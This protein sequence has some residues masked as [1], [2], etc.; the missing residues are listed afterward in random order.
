MKFVIVT[1]GTEGDV[2]PLA[3]LAHALV[4]AGH[5][6]R[7][8][9]PAAAL[10]MAHALGVE[11]V[12]LA[13]NVDGGPAEAGGISGAVEQG[14]DFGGAAAAMARIANAHAEVWTRQTLAAAEGCD[15]IILS[16]LAAFVG[17]SVAERLGAKAI[18]AGFIPI[19]PTLAFPS[20][21]LPRFVPRP[22]NRFSHRLVNGLLWR[23]FSNAMNAARGT[24]L[25][26]PPRRAVW[27]DH[28]MLY[29]VS[30]SIL[31]QPADWPDNA[32]VCGQW[33]APAGDWAPP[34]DLSAFLSAG[35]PP[36]YVGFGSMTGFD[37]PRMT[38]ALL[39]AAVE[40]R[41]IFSPGWSGI[42]PAGLPANI[43]AVGD[44]PH[45]WL[46]PRTSLVVHHGGS[47]S[48][49]SAC[50]AG[51]PSVVVPF[52][53]D[54]FFWADRLKALGVA[55]GG[56]RAKDISGRTLR[57]AIEFAERDVV[58]GRAHAVGQAMATE[59]GLSRA[60]AAIDVLMGARPGFDN[61]M[62]I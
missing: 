42:D 30:P 29:G 51:V 26:L 20:P 11:T 35:K 45:A 16:G 46:F 38:E 24:V 49:H 22:L 44:T 56:V 8:L 55:P 54:Q 58:R 47:G 19:T 6:A 37:K 50:R 5:E 32:L 61:S 25:G 60:L 33:A 21:F 52:A 27:A 31:P 12:P 41:V 28:P 3:A 13:G 40:R 17:L 43:F 36:I 18:G 23:A 34:A 14:G 4:G 57:R 7:L 39:E 2:R 10:G 15:A 1:Y 62:L 9:G 59:D 53:G 48:A